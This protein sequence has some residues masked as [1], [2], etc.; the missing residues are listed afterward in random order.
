MKAHVPFPGLAAPGRRRR[1]RRAAP[2]CA[3]PHPGRGAGGE[4]ARRH[5]W[6][7]GRRGGLGGR[8]LTDDGWLRTG[9][10]AR[11]RPVRHGP[12]PGPVE[13]R[14]QGGR[15]LG[16][17]RGGRGGAGRA[18]G[19]RRGRRAWRCPTPGWARCRSR[20]SACP[21]VE[22]GSRR[23]RPRGLLAAAAAD[24]APYKRPRRL[25][26]VDELPRTGS[27]KVQKD[28]LRPCSLTSEGPASRNCAEDAG[29]RQ[30]VGVTLRGGA[31]SGDEDQLQVVSPARRTQTL[32]TFAL[33]GS[34]LPSLSMAHTLT[35]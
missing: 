30:R 6:L 24:L 16:L 13:G 25:V 15:L 10:R 4:G 17:R 14:D 7:L 19:H 32:L 9:D 34:G 3:V 23:P 5:E 35:R 26:I 29:L 1:R 31:E 27:G 33:N 28:R 8:P 21:R 11:A 2:R 22:G 20:P 12:L 18:P